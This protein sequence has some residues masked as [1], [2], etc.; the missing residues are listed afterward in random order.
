MMQYETGTLRRLQ[1]TELEI[2]DAIAALCE[3]NNIK[4]FLDSGSA[5][6]AV[7]HQ[8]FIPWDDDIDI[9][10][11][12]QD[13][14]RF[15]DIA[16]RE[17]APDYYLCTPDTTDHY[18]VTFA[19]V[20]KTGTK[21]FTEES[22]DAGFE[23]GI[24]VD[25]FPYDH[26]SSN[27]RKAGMQRFQAVFLVRA[28][29]LYYSKNIVVPNK[30][31]VG[32]LQKIACTWAHYIVRAFAD[33][34]AIKSRFKQLSLLCSAQEGGGYLIF[35]YPYVGPFPYSMLNNL[36]IMSFEGRTFPVPNDVKN[37]L[38]ICYGPNWNVLP[39]ESKR[40]NHAPLVLDFGNDEHA[41][42]KGVR[43]DFGD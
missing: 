8:G 26:I 1:L 37:Y 27:P 18:S 32:R 10:M 21:F 15:L 19:K 25:V 36:E 12:R 17:L 40:K 22:I 14:D 23:P 41:L 13:Y 39:P 3:K 2:L 38:E 34:A 43:R 24:F 11:P 31:F 16:P 7:R 29:Y 9:G 42:R 20:C 28:L 30:G 33:E 4:W 35:S 6:G 5:L